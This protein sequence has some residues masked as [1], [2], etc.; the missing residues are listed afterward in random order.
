MSEVARI[1]SPQEIESYKTPNGGWTRHDLEMWGVSWPPVD[2][3]K[4]ELEKA[5][6]LG[7]TVG[8]VLECI[9][10]RKAK[11]FVDFD[12]YPVC[13]DC[14][15]WEEH[16]YKET[17]SETYMIRQI[18]KNVS[19]NGRREGFIGKI[20]NAV[21][22]YKKQPIPPEIRWAVWER[23]NFTC[24]HCGSRKNL[25]VDHIFPESKGGETTIENCQTLCKSCNSRK[26]AR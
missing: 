21:S 11:F 20:A 24:K 16:R 6:R 25:S 17:H 10:C 15:K 18:E 1:P 4:E 5:Y 2:G 23:D 7:F 14:Q 8:V 26:G 3:W 12:Q 19:H 9:G 13:A 22:K